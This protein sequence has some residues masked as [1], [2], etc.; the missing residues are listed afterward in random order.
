MASRHSQKDG[1]AFALNPFPPPLWD[2]EHTV[3][4]LLF[5]HAKLIPDLG[6]SCLVS[7]P[8]APCALFL[9]LSQVCSKLSS[10]RLSLST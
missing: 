4:L 3:L 5:E 9:H 10:E 7:L 2:T 1:L 6:S 8:G